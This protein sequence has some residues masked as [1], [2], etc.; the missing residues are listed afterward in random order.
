MGWKKHSSRK[1]QTDWSETVLVNIP[2]H[3]IVEQCR[4]MLQQRDNV[5]YENSNYAN[6]YSSLRLHFSFFHH[7]V[8]AGEAPF[9]CSWWRHISP[10][11]T[12][13]IYLAKKTD[14]EKY[15]NIMIKHHPSREWSENWMQI[16]TS[17]LIYWYH[18]DLEHWQRMIYHRCASSRC[19][20]G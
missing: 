13:V 14:R 6:E 19:K 4:L 7:P 20:S 8:V 11:A 18:T 15:W 12:P 3:Q 5:V 10:S 17:V 2:D 1:L 9:G 16:I